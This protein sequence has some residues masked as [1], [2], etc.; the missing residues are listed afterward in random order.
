MLKIFPVVCFVSNAL[1]GLFLVHRGR[2]RLK[3]MRQ[4]GEE[5]EFWRENNLF[6]QVKIGLFDF[7]EWIIARKEAHKIAKAEEEAKARAAK[8]RKDREEQLAQSGDFVGE[9][10]QS[11]DS[12]LLIVGLAIVVACVTLIC[13]ELSSILLAVPFLAVAACYFYEMS[14]SRSNQ[15]PIPAALVEKVMREQEQEQKA[16]EAEGS[17]VDAELETIENNGKQTSEI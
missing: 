13:S 4:S 8:E 2:K 3:R 9:C 7:T 5:Y 16:K 12:P 17:T 1:F 14:D 11:S 10:M 6:Y 15:G